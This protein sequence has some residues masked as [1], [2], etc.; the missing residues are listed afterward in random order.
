M[1]NQ[2]ETQSTKETTEMID[3]DVRSKS[4]FGK[5]LKFA[6]IGT[7][8]ALAGAA[9][10]HVVRKNKAK[11]EFEIDEDDYFG[12]DDTED[13]GEFELIETDEVE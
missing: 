12:D 11:S 1:E 7:L 9:I 13:S 4:K 2:F 6:A 3:V 10:C 8:A 5:G